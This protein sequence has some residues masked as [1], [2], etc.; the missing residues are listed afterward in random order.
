MFPSDM[1][2]QVTTKQL[3]EALLQSY[4]ETHDIGHIYN[5]DGTELITV[6]GASKFID[7]LKEEASAEQI[8]FESSLDNMMEEFRNYFPN[9]STFDL[10]HNIWNKNVQIELGKK[11]N[12][13]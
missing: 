7:E 5:D 13:L 4:I 10:M 12:N 8:A 2:K 3:L 1:E 6:D 11:Y 9:V